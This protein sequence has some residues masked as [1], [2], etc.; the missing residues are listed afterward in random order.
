[1]TIYLVISGRMYMCCHA[2]WIF[3]YFL[4]LLRQAIFL[5][6]RARHFSI[7]EPIFNSLVIL[8]FHQQFK[9]RPI[10]DFYFIQFPLSP[11]LNYNW[12]VVSFLLAFL[13]IF[14]TLHIWS[15]NHL[16]HFF[17]SWSLVTSK[18]SCRWQVFQLNLW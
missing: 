15:T 8:W 17:L 16:P 18:K 10:I 9:N 5:T 4:K 2:P 7:Y 12:W 1:M 11:F 14:E 13:S 6:F 3:Q